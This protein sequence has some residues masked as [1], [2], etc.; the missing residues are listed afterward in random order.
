MRFV[1]VA[2]V[3]AAC[4][5]PSADAP[6]EAEQVIAPPDT[7]RADWGQHFAA[8]DARGTFVM[9]DT[10]TGLI[11]RY[12][13][14]RA[15]TRFTPASTSKVFNGLVFLDQGV[16]ADVDSMYAWDGV[17]RS[18]RS[19]NRDHSLRTG[20]EF[21][22]VW[23][24]QRL[25]REVSREGYAEVF[26]RYPYGN[27]TMGEPL[28]MAWLDGS[29]RVSADEQIAFIDALRT[30]DLPFS[31]AHQATIREILPLL[32]EGDGW[33]LKAK[34][35]WGIPPE[36]PPIGWLVGWVERP[37]GDV[38]FAMNA[39]ADGPEWD[40][41]PDRIRLVQRILEAEGVTSAR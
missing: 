29:W 8:M 16:V 4:S 41:G 20:T 36:E 11:S 14:E 6:P 7:V 38:V 39:E 27:A 33:R 9:L 10:G 17:E 1:F 35:G 26:A 23:L 2:L 32:V 5:S 30:G 13:P 21:S 22:A 28:E 12:N 25:A 19:W 18:I 40:M 37:D 24:F 31:D 3:L 15:A 34:T